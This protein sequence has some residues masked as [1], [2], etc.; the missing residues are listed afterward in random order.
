MR[1][2][3]STCTLLS[4]L[5]LLSSC[6]PSM[7]LTDRGNDIYVNGVK[8]GTERAEIAR[9]GIPKGTSIDIKQ[10]NKTVNTYRLKRKFTVN[11]AILTLAFGWFGLGLGWQYPKSTYIKGRKSTEIDEKNESIW[12][13]PPKEKSIWE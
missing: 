10:G 3:T 8:Y 11:T 13:K 12:S 1:Y 6:A 9:T 7:I 4:I 2:F 5:I